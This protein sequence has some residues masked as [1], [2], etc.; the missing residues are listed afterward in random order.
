MC[1]VRRE[2]NIFAAACTVLQYMRLGQCSVPSFK[3]AF[4]CIYFILLFFK[5]YYPSY[6]HLLHRGMA[7]TD[8]TF[9]RVARTVWRGVGLGGPAASPGGGQGPPAG[10]QGQPRLRKFSI[11]LLKIDH[12]ETSEF[13]ILG[14]LHR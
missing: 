8:C 11:F 10:L 4:S 9:R 1:A 12:S 5:S 7:S 3:H 13:M 14:S 6:K 2:L